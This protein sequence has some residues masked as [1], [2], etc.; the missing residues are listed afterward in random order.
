MEIRARYLLIGLFVLVVAAAGIGFVFWLSN[1]GG[2]A[3]R[4]PYQVRFEGSISGLS[5]GS[6]VLFNGVPVGEVTDLGLIADAPGEVMAT[7]SVARATPVRTDTRVGLVF[8]GLTGT[9]EVALVGGAPDSAPLSASGD[10]PSILV[11]EPGEIKDMTQAARDVLGRLNTILADNADSLHDAISNIDTF[12]GALARNSTKIDGIL[13]GLERLTGGKAE[14]APTSFD[15]TA[16]KDFPGLGPLP[17]AQLAVPNPTA[18]IALD[19]QRIIEQTADGEAPAFPDARWVDNLPLVFQAR[20]IQ[21][22][23][24]AGYLKVGTDAGGLHADYQLAIAI[25]QFR[26]AT[27]PA[28]ASAQVA[29]AAKILDADGKIVAAKVFEANAPAPAVD[30]AAHSVSALDAAFGRATTDLIGWAL[31]AINAAVAAAP[32]KVDAGMPPD[33]NAPDANKPNAGKPEAS[34]PDAGKPDANAAAPAD[35]APADPSQPADSPAAPAPA[36]QAK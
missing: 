21:S 20:I 12:S 23:E 27:A 34:K 18:V 29:F 6:A 16:P 35:A 31:G 14:T 25:R 28:P 8:S 2:L 30:T 11:A 4:T 9:A 33:L 5:R 36:T 10:Q 32:P 26:I 17:D 22:F 19:N 3:E 15:L 7:I 1:S 13:Q 24:N